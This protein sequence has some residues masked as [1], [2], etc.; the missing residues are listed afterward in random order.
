MASTAWRWVRRGFQYF[1]SYMSI[2]VLGLGFMTFSAYRR[3]LISFDSENKMKQIF[4][5]IIAII[6]IGYVLLLLSNSKILI[7]ENK[8]E[9]NVNSKQASLV[10]RY[11]IGR[12]I[13]IRTYWY[14]PNNIFGKDSCPFLLVD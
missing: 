10:C 13:L 14:A 11:F 7:S 12:H 3:V 4:L 1:H 5:C 6:L 9:P 2:V 8:V